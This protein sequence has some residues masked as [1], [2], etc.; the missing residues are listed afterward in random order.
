MRLCASA[1]CGCSR[2]CVRLACRWPFCRAR[3]SPSAVFFL[4]SPT[5]F[6]NHYL[7]SAVA[8]YLDNPF[9]GSSALVLA[10]EYKKCT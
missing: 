8:G 7:L 6:Q 9:A 2:V 5:L 10:I 4:S 3:F 1:L